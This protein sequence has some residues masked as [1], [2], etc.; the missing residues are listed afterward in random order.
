M[1]DLAP[2][3]TTP[4]RP[5]LL[6]LALDTG[7]SPVLDG[8]FAEALAG[9]IAA[10]TGAVPEPTP[11][12][13]TGANLE[14]DVGTGEAAAMPIDRQILAA[15]GIA[16]PEAPDVGA[17]DATAPQIAMSGA[18]ETR[19]P[20]RED[21]APA[22][23][24]EAGGSPDGALEAALA[25]LMP[26]PPAPP[27]MLPVA[28]LAIATQPRG[29]AML[30]GTIAALPI[31][32][33]RADVA[34]D[35]TA[36]GTLGS[37]P[38]AVAQE[39]AGKM[40]VMRAL[41][42]ASS[43]TA[44]DPQSSD[45]VLPA[46]RTPTNGPAAALQ[47]IAASPASPQSGDGG[48]PT[49]EVSSVPRGVVRVPPASGSTSGA[50]G[51]PG[52]APSPAPV[53]AM[54]APGT[55]QSP[56]V[57]SPVREAA[58]VMRRSSREATLPAAAPNAPAP[59]SPLAT[60]LA[61]N[62]SLSIATVDPSRRRED[63]LVPLSLDGLVVRPL[64]TAAPAEA[65]RPGID[66]TRDAGLHR[67]VDRIERLRDAAA[68]E[69]VVARDTRI[70]LVPDS[71][72]PVEIAV[73]REGEAVQVHFT[74]SEATTRQLIADAQPRLTELAEARGVRIDRATV[75]GGQ[76]GQPGGQPGHNRPPPQQPTPARPVSHA[77]DEAETPTEHRIA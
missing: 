27:P 24:V 21:P 62:A 34:S 50:L 40:P 75:D 31:A 17:V 66:L 15:R 63:P 30:A 46:E 5:G 57:P 48:A 2:S 29:N 77:A 54:P 23:D 13:T 60:R 71:L 35:V 18:E 64:A 59:L 49:E 41:S 36:D 42:D 12:A 25:W 61:A 56:V 72:G 16:L 8:G 26:P 73:R 1:I 37:P 47:A 11:T 14:L 32:A 68:M 6:P 9:M 3:L 67:M 10:A 52:A 38:L 39:K 58:P 7:G 45:A 33:M 28:V 70:R 22:S 51:S 53:G 74:A 69:G 65:S 55:A 43:V 19:E 4:V 44:F 20:A 76:T